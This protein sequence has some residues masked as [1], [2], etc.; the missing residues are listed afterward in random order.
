[1]PARHLVCYWFEK[2]RAQIAAGKAKRVG[3]LATQAIRGGANR[4]VLERIKETGD[5]FWAQSDRNWVLDGATVHVS[6]VGFDAWREKRSELDGQNGSS[7]QLRSDWRLRPDK[8]KISGEFRNRLHRTITKRG[9]FD[10]GRGAEQ[11]LTASSE[12]QWPVRTV[13]CCAHVLMRI[14]FTAI[15]AGIWIIDFGLECPWKKL[16][17][18]SNLLSMSGKNVKP[19]RA[20]KQRRPYRRKWWQY[21]SHDLFAQAH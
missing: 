12:S 11:C 9:K 4:K 18:T 1:M 7:Y 8:L 2:A 17:Y 19:I 5:I 16:L 6:M 10:I 13:M 15:L 20:E 21:A 3:L 14:D